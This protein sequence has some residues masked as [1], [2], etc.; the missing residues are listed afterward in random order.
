MMSKEFL[1][2]QKILKSKADKEVK[3]SAKKFVPTAKKIY[4][5][6]ALE[7]N[8]LAVKYKIVGFKL[9]EELWKSGAFEEKL[10]ATKILGKVCKKDSDLT[11]KLIKKFSK[12]ISDW[13]VCDTLATQGIIGIIKI[14]QKE[15][16]QIAKKL[17]NSK[18][19]WK[20]RFAI[21]LLI[22]FV[23][24]KNLKKEIEKIVKTVENDKEYYVKKAVDW[25]KRKMK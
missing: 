13:A 11:L 21:V 8:K 19:F 5:V 14:K 24:D 22:N 12:D 6:K 1:E 2:I 3:V 25:I 9:A 7:L 4:G 17:I 16:L 18:N 20:R 15:I 10:L 23:K